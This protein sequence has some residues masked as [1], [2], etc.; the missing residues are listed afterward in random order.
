[1]VKEYNNV[2]LGMV[3]VI[4]LRNTFIGVRAEEASTVSQFQKF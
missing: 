1:M 2:K 3:Q 4:V